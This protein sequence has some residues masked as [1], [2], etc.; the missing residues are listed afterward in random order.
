[1]GMGPGG[2]DVPFHILSCHEGRV[3][4]GKINVTTR[5]ARKK[6]RARV[7]LAS[8]YSMSPSRRMRSACR[9]KELM[10]ASAATLGPC[11]DSDNT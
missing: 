10:I 8:T 2:G 3:R 6:A 11:R 5:T 4:S 7:W 9:R 1:M